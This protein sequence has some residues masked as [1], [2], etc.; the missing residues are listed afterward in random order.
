M[1]LTYEWSITAVKKATSSNIDDAIVGTRWKVVGTDEDG[2]TGEFSGATPFDL[3]SINTGSFTSYQDLTETQVLDW[4]KNV[5]SGSSPTNY[6]SHINEQITKQID[7]SKLSISEVSEVHLPWSPTSG[8]SDT[9][10]PL[11]GNTVID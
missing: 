11:A 8:S 1:A 7:R 4:I 6:W 9:P 2:N 3:N 10:D 5:V